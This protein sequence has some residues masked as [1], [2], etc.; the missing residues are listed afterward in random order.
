MTK[1]I[2]DP[3]FYG[4]GG[5]YVPNRSSPAYSTAKQFA[6]RART[7]GLLDQYLESGHSVAVKP[8]TVSYDRADA[9]GILGEI[10][11]EAITGGPSSGGSSSGGGG[12]SGSSKGGL[13]S[14]GGFDPEPEPEPNP[15]PGTETF[16]FDG[17]SYDVPD[18]N[19]DGDHTL[20]DVTAARNE[21]S[22]AQFRVGGND[23]S[24]SSSGSGGSSGGLTSGGGSGSDQDDSSQDTTTDDGSSGSDADTQESTSMY[25]FITDSGVSLSVPDLNDDGESTPS[26]LTV[27][28]NR[29]TLSQYATG[30]SDGQSSPSTGSPSSG[31]DG[32]IMDDIGPAAIVAALA[33]IIIV[34]RGS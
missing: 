9:L 34:M 28:R 10:P 4:P 7:K 6:V 33:L 32:S 15:A 20:A 8:G 5:I 11:D 22:L 17:R 31:S 24:G 2:K 19:E 16:E 30:S 12:D 18:V 27:A 29:G 23:S 21:G 25:E 13:T 1:T 3:G 26:D 14:G